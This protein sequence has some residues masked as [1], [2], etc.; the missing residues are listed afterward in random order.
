MAIETK[1]LYF[2]DPYRTDFEA[3]VLSR[4]DLLEGQA[5]ILDQTCFYP[6]GGGQ[7]A[8]RGI[9]CGVEVKHVFEQGGEILHL[10]ASPVSD[11]G[12]RGR[13]DWEARFDHMQQHS[14]QH[15]LSQCFHRLLNGKTVSFHLGEKIS[16]LEIALPSITDEDVARVEDCANRAVF[17]NR[18]IQTYFVD[19]D[20][21]VRVPL[22]KPPQKAG[23]IRV[24]EVAGFDFTA[25]GG[26]HPRRTGEIGCIKLLKQVKIRN[27]VRFEFVSGGRALQDYSRKQRILADLALKFSSGEADLPLAVDKMMT[28]QKGLKRELRK[29]GERVLQHEALEMVREVDEPVIAKLF[30]EGSAQEVRQ[31]ALAVIRNSGFVTLFGLRSGDKAHLIMA[32]SEDLALDLRDLIPVVSP[33]LDAKGGGRPSLVELVGKNPAALAA[34]LDRARGAIK[35]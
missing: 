22:R 35:L 23:R 18:E 5:L 4:R 34:A 6:E 10:V 11:D 21:I 26:T 29:V 15:V 33:L 28:E 1:R 24:V 25:C 30:E 12:V 20:E 16:T 13:I 9:L 17:E 7:P 31:L 14:G 2:E 3:R 27:N 32:R 8:D 19:E